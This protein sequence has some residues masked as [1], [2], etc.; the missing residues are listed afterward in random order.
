MTDSSPFCSLQF[1]ASPYLTLSISLASPTWNDEQREIHNG[2]KYPCP[3]FSLDSHFL[4]LIFLSMPALYWQILMMTH[5][6]LKS[7]SLFSTDNGIACS[8]GF[9]C[10]CL[11]LSFDDVSWPLIGSPH[12]SLSHHYWLVST[13]FLKHVSL[14]LISNYLIIFYF[15]CDYSEMTKRR[16]RK[17]FQYLCTIRLYY[18]DVYFYTF[19]ANLPLLPYILL[20]LSPGPYTEKNLM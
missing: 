15:Y 9:C 7:F 12:F 1:L 13:L 3:K 14:F 16:K 8:G 18:L 10:Y 6:F 5:A 20:N 17:I 4:C 11:I 2:E 19:I